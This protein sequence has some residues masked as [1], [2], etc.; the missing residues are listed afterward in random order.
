MRLGSKMHNPVDDLLGKKPIQK[1][2]VL[3][4]PMNKVMSSCLLWG[5]TFKIGEIAGVGQGIKINNA[6]A[7]LLCK[8]VADKVCTDKTSTAS[9]EEGFLLHAPALFD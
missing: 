5:E 4:G 1:G 6:P 3:Y 2:A 8:D 7:W 9:Y